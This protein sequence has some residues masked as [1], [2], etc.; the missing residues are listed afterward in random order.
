MTDEQAK[1]LR[2]LA[3]R[4]RDAEAAYIAA[5]DGPSRVEERRAEYAHG[6]ARRELCAAASPDVLLA[7][8]DERDAAMA[9]LRVAHE[10]LVELV[11]EYPVSLP[12][13]IKRIDA[14]LGDGGEA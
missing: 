5:Q 14:L 10:A 4:A 13:I 12:P 7:L 9:L 6:T 1:W 11:D 8:L 3:E 2:A